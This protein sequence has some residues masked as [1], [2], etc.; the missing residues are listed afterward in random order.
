MRAVGGATASGATQ[1]L[2]RH[3]PLLLP[4][5]LLEGAER[6]RDRGRPGGV[7]DEVLLELAFVEA[8]REIAADGL[9]RFSEERWVG[10]DDMGQINTL[11]IFQI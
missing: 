5:L 11:Q 8:Q 2:L 10:G 3:L 7:V 6:A 4:Q 1:P 9:V